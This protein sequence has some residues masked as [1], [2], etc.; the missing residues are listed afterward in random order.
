MIRRGE[1]WWAD[2]S[3][4]IGSAPG[5]RRPVLI[6]QD[7]AFNR[8]TIRTTIAAVLSSNLR[9]ADAPGNVRVSARA[10]G[11]PRDSVVNVSQVITLD[12]ESLTERIGRLPVRSVAEVDAGLR[13]VLGLG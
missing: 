10:S 7:D 8:S 5:H 1:L 2:L 3:D 4:P 12:R 6:V 9:L 13:L 11:L